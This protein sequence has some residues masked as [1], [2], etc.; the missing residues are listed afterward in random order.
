M[1]TLGAYIKCQEVQHTMVGG[2]D[3]M[4]V[5]ILSD[6]ERVN[7]ESFAEAGEGLCNLD[8]G[9]KLVPPLWSQNREES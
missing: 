3:W 9:R 1:C 2:R 8:I 6:S 4:A 7:F 5:Q